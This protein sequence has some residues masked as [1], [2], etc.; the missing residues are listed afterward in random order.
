M[1]RLRRVSAMLVLVTLSACLQSEP[2]DYYRLVPQGPPPPSAAPA[3][4]SLVGLELV[5]IPPASERGEI[6]LAEEGNALD[7]TA[8]DAWAAPLDQMITLVTAE[9]LAAH[10]GLDQVYVLPARRFVDLDRVV[11][12][13]IVALDMTAAGE[14]EVTALWRLFNRADRLLA[15]GRIEQ[16]QGFTPGDDLDPAVAA[17]NRALTAMTAELAAAIR[18]A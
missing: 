4:S 1:T 2:T 7:V 5:S 14:V 18:S 10:L 11:E 8:T 17:L 9:D 13:E 16:R 15:S 12:L 3:G 6:V